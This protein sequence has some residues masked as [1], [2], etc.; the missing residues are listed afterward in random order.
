MC[1][2]I[3]VEWAAGQR[4][5]DMTLA[6]VNYNTVPYG[7]APAE[8]LKL[9]A[10]YIG[11]LSELG[12][13]HEIHYFI[14][15]E[16]DQEY[17]SQGINCHYIDSNRKDF[18]Q[19]VLHRRLRKLQ[20][21]IIFVYGLYFN[22]QVLWLRRMLGNKIRIVLQSHSFLPARG[23]RIW[24][25]RWCY[26]SVSAYFFVSYDLAARWIRNGNFPGDGKVIEIMPA[27]SLLHAMDQQEAR[28]YTG[29]SGKLNFLWVGRLNRN[30]DPITVMDA[31]LE[32]AGRHT[33]AKLYM[34][35]QQNDMPEEIA[36]KLRGDMGGNIVMIGN[37]PNKDLAFWYSSADFFI[38]GSHHESFGLALCEALSCGA[39][40][41]VPAIPSFEK[42]TAN[43]RYGS[44]FEVGDKGSLLTAMQQA[45][46][47]DPAEKRKQVIGFFKENLSFPAIALRLEEVL[48][49]I[50][51]KTGS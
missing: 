6:F 50:Q 11:I 38:S 4:S 18:T 21:Q 27:S 44:L 32:F 34:I 33:E 36:A 39:Y 5:F 25:E 10:P 14:Y 26:S 35:Y 20:P 45:I 42:M 12:K 40:P 30:K 1:G 23:Y 29:M 22:F 37:V 13:K 15:A 49:A 2:T 17:F 7:T 48:I 46:K 3:W 28:V 47:G 51:N 16:K 9:V 41:V 24:M 19:S 31:F 8:W 43:G